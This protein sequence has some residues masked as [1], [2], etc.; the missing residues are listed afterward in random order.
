VADVPGPAALSVDGSP[1]GG[2]DP[3][4]R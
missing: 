4:V 2:G 3:C 1:W